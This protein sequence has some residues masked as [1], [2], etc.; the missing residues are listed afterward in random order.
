MTFTERLA[1]AAARHP[2]RTLALWIAALLASLVTIVLLISSALSGDRVLY[3]TESLRGHD[4]IAER[5]GDADSPE[6]VIVRSQ[7]MRI[8]DAAF[9]VEVEGLTRQIEATGGAHVTSV[10]TNPGAVL[11]SDDHMATTIPVTLLGDDDSAKES[12][13]EKI[14]ALVEKADREGPLDVSIVGEFTLDLDRET[15]AQEDLQK[16]ELFFGLPMAMVI[17]VLVFGALVAASLPLLIAVLSI[18][19]AVALVTIIGQA[20]HPSIFV[21]NMVTA[22]GLA[23]GI[24]YSLF[25]VARFREERARGRDKLAAIAATGSTSSRAV[26]FSGAVFVLALLGMLLV[27]DSILR[28]LALGAVLVGIVSVAAALTLLPALLSL[29]GDRV[30]SLPVPLIGRR[31]AATGGG[32]G[33]FWSRTAHAVMR[34]PLVGLLSATALLVAAAAPVVDLTIRDTGLDDFPGY[35]AS[36]KGFVALNEEFPQATAEPIKI[37][38]AGDLRSPGLQSAI[39]RL[40]TSLRQNDLFGRQTRETSEAGDLSVIAVTTGG[41]AQS[42]RATDAVRDLRSQ[43]IPAAFRGTG[44]SVMVTGTAAETLDGQEMTNMWLPRVLLFV[45]AL[46]FVVLMLA[47]RSIVVPLKAIVL[48]LLSVGAAYGLMTLVFE[49]GVGAELLGFEEVESVTSW[50]PL[51]LFS[52]LFALSMD[53][54]VFLLSRIKERYDRTGDNTAAIAYG[55]SSS[56]RLITGAALI[57]VAVFTGFAIGDLPMFQQMGFGLA[58]ALF[59][60]ATVIRSVLLPASMKLLGDANWYLPSWLSWLPRLDA[61]ETV[62]EPPAPRPAS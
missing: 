61:V 59:I 57:M 54:H 27:P 60:D 30:N 32:E 34:R 62:E 23:L 2:V 35:L 25:V 36:K 39:Q 53:Y 18:V 45:L 43:T 21:V 7:T 22:M 14:G 20:W 55:V 56:A 4:L 48:N 10:Y 15:L 47:F 42:A 33:R 41:D 38:I 51:F 29:L 6:I 19:V 28:S 17:L 52:V 8:D 44:A 9:R 50:V 49:K 26:F 24:D 3:G 31:V 16:G 1:S 11:V 12:S 5:L 46:S 40:Q 13:A 37:V 58:V